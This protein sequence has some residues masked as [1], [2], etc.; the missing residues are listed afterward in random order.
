[1]AAWAD[2]VDYVG[3]W[4][5]PQPPASRS[6]PRTSWSSLLRTILKRFARSRQSIRKTCFTLISYVADDSEKQT[7]K[8]AAVSA[9]LAQDEEEARAQA[10]VAAKRKQAATLEAGKSRRS[11]LTCA[12]GCRE[13]SRSFFGW[14]QLARERAPARAAAG[15]RALEPQLR[16]GSQRPRPRAKSGEP[17]RQS[18]SRPRRCRGTRGTPLKVHP[19]LRVAEGNDAHRA[20]GSFRR[21][22]VGSQ[23]LSKKE[24]IDE[25]ESPH[26]L[27]TP[28]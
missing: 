14:A 25:K 28:P 11:P 20:R 24:K 7:H 4:T 1:M 5:P 15:A 12:G 27:I 16:S 3:E 21:E 10:A 26:P 6:T 22:R 9:K 13:L 17:P 2:E 19:Q 23:P 8:K 18:R